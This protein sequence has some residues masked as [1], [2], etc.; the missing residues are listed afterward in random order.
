ML[1]LWLLSLTVCCGQQQQLRPLMT[2]PSRSPTT[3]RYNKKS[4]M[5]KMLY[6]IV[7]PRDRIDVGV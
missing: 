3:D 1:S 6:A 2:R 7:T 5:P 4:G